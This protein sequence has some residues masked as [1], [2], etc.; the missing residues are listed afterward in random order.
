M[1]QSEYATRLRMDE[2]NLWGGRHLRLARL[3]VELTERCNSNC[4]HCCINLPVDD[5]AAE[6]EEMST[7]QVKDI[8]TEAVVM[9]YMRVKLSGGEPLLREDFEEIYYFARKLGLK[10]LVFTNATLITPQLAELFARVPPLDKVEVSVYGMKEKSYEAV[11]RIPGSYEAAWRGIHLLEEKGV[12]FVVKGTLLPPVKGE[13]GE[14]EAWASTIPGMELSPRYAIFLDLRFRR[15]SETKNRLIEG[16]RFSPEEGLAFL[17]RKPEEYLASK[18]RFCSRFVG[19]RDDKLFSCG[20]GLGAC[21]VD[22]YGYFLP[23]TLLRD[24]ELIYD[25]KDGSIKDALTNVFPNLRK[26]RAKNPDYLARCARCFLRGICEQCPG[27]SWVE[28]G[29]LDT[30]VEY[31][32]KIAH[33]QARYCGLIGDDEM[34]WEVDDWRDRIKAFSNN[35]EINH[36]DNG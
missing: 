12:P 10:V 33:A 2:S 22:A 16:L 31:L 30:P 11:T 3:D 32:C 9:G 26:M 23:C 1:R 17:T 27:K 7:E 34:A 13:R 5:S 28:N 18:R 14:F 8:L 15:D 19:R 6:R 29:T 24:P 25:L 35:E 20:A 36:Q 21:C 4:I